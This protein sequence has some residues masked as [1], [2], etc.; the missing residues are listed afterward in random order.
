MSIVV[1]NVV[2]LTPRLAAHAP[3]LSSLGAPRPLAGPTP[4][5]TCTAQATM[6]TGVGPDVHGIVGNGWLY[7]DTGE[8]R[9][10][11]QSRRLIQSP[12]VY[13]AGF[14]DPDA[15]PLRTAKMFWWFNGDAPVDYAC[16]PK[17]FY[18]SD[19]GKVFAV[20]DRTGC[21][22]VGRLGEFPFFSFWGPRSG[23]PSSRWIADATS[24]VIREKRPE[25]T[26]VYLPHLDYDHQRLSDP[27]TSLITEV[28][29][30]AKT[31][32]DA[33]VEIDATVIAVSE[34]GLT[35]VHRPVHINRVFRE[36]DLVTVRPGPYG[37][38]LVPGLCDAVAV[39]DHQVAHVYFPKSSTTLRGVNSDPKLRRGASC[40]GSVRRILEQTPGIAAV[41]DPREIGLSHPRAGDLIALSDPDAWFTYYHW[42]DDDDAPDYART[43]DIHRKPGYDPVELFATSNLRAAARLAQKKLGFRYRMDVTP[44]DATLVKGSHGLQPAD[45]HDGAV[46]IAPDTPSP[47][48]RMEEVPE[49]IRQRTSR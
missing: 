44:L 3:H 11:Q 1:I 16:T 20:D 8:I 19:G 4:M 25:L 41:V 30:C 48:G 27:P 43:V 5:V 49:Y 42:I 29:E 7:P 36:H 40:Y 34:Y 15:P 24:I 17:P 23:L 28:D 45:P 46:V 12:V 2:G 6:L 33:A 9:F 31:I 32:I 26:L 38:A 18:G 14:G 21:N 35:P 10:W 37:D 39:A 47:P 13:E 22:L